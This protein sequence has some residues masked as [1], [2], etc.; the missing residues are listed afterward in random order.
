M[1]FGASVPADERQELAAIVR[2]LGGSVVPLRTATHLVEFN[3]EVDGAAAAGADEQEYCRTIAVDR[4]AKLAQV[5][6]W[7]YPDSYDSWIP[8]TDV[9]GKVRGHGRAAAVA[10][11]AACMSEHVCDAHHDAPPWPRP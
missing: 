7:Y 8:L 11:A 9:S 6:W 10:A 4:E 3:P 5:H 2:K 1:H